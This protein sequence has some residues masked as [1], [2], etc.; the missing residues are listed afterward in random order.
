MWSRKEN[1]M[2]LRKLTLRNLQKQT[3]KML[4][5]SNTKY[6]VAEI[7]D[8]VRVRVQDVYRA[9]SVGINVLATVIEMA[10]SNCINWEKYMV[11]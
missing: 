11:L 9:L 6:P 5:A 3:N 8:T 2:L 10:G 1:V 4:D 7:V